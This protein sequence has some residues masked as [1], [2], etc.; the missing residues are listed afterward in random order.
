MTDGH[1]APG[2]GYSRVGEIEADDASRAM[3][4]MRAWIENGTADI[5]FAMGTP[6]MSWRGQPTELPES[7]EL[8]SA[9]EEG[10]LFAREG[11]T[12]YILENDGRVRTM[13]PGTSS[14]MQI[15]EF[16]KDSP[17]ALVSKLNE[18]SR[19]IKFGRT[20]AQLVLDD[21]H[22]VIRKPS[23]HPAAHHQATV[24][25]YLFTLCGA[26]PTH[27]TDIDVYLESEGYIAVWWNAQSKS[28]GSEGF[29]PGVIKL[30]FHVDEGVN[31][32]V[33]VLRPYLIGLNTIKFNRRV[34]WDTEATGVYQF[35]IPQ[36]W[37]A[38]WDDTGPV[39]CYVDG[40]TWRFVFQKTDDDTA[41]PEVYC[42]SLKTLQGA[43]LA[44]VD[45]ASEG[46]CEHLV[47]AP[48]VMAYLNL[49]FT[50]HG[51]T[52]EEA[53][54]QVNASGLTL[55]R[56]T[57]SSN[58]GCKKAL[59][60]VDNLEWGDEILEGQVY[61]DSD[62]DVMFRSS[63]EEYEPYRTIDQCLKGA[64]GDDGFMPLAE[65][66]LALKE[67]LAINRQI[68]DKRGWLATFGPLHLK[69]MPEG[70]TF[71]QIHKTAS[72]T[73]IWFWKPETKRWAHARA[74]EN[75]LVHITLRGH[76][77]YGVHTYPEILEALRA[78]GV[79]I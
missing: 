78:T 7:K 79:K 67:P 20:A 38:G 10:W 22:K 17:P 49:Q 37:S 72:N 45:E 8:L 18:A 65:A 77:L 48:Y 46:E 4:K 42:Y 3:D 60:D 1:S 43:Q 32:I 29:D 15:Q 55:T 39:D 33:Q 57:S 23:M 5:T 27:G 34:S 74:E 6:H 62:W 25:G 11:D 68:V 13:G 52:P 59:F 31:A 14:R 2:R 75:N 12:R 30:G 54:A 51:D 53:E 41:G 35:T 19:L 76:L 28:V 66:F 63:C 9:V 40:S 21:G 44:G 64:F 58:T 47:F 70:A 56:I 61:L 71:I 26:Q 69:N 36:T 73:K 16:R 24:G 50:G